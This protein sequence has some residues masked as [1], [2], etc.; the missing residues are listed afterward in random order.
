M[1]I[2]GRDMS[3]EKKFLFKIIKAQARLLIAYRLGIRPPEWAFDILTQ[4]KL[5]YGQL[6][7]IKIS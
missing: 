4:A 6:H 3:K 5:K 2:T 7:K 1:E